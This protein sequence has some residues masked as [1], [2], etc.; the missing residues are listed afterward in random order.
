MSGDGLLL[1]EVALALLLIGAAGGFLSGLLGVGGGI[2]Y[3]PS[4]FFALTLLQAGGDHV[5]HIAVGSSLA[6]VTL[7]VAT[8][9]RA[10]YKKGG[11][12]MSIIRQWGPFILAGVLAGS[13]VAGAVDGRVLQQ[14]FAVI[15]MAVAMYMAFG[16][17]SMDGAGARWLTLSIQRFF[18]ALIGVAAALTGMGGAI[19]TVPMMS[20]TGV[21]MHRAS[22]TGAA[23]GLLVAIPGMIG[24]VVTGWGQA[25]LPPFSMGYVNL[26]VVAFLM[27]L[28][29]L[30]AP[31]GVA[32]AHRTDRVILRRI[33]A[34]V[35][36]VVSV[37]MFM[38]I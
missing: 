6:I 11:V 12:D 16:R 20:A 24:Y 8:S 28:S 32:V 30:M 37:R 15:T 7:T 35:V 5:M 29:I 13:A 26:A 27:P 1:F 23:M 34:G 21:S 38:S 31:V 25:D 10:H 19:L 22:G 2:I 3:V 9:S 33:F 36:F 4:L 14:V 18:C 17:E